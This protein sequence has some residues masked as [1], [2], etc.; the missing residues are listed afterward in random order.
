MLKVDLHIHT[1]DDPIDRI[2]HSSIELIDRAAEL[3]YGAIAITLHDRQIETDELTEY[4][5]KRGVVLIPGIERTV[6]GRHVLLLNFPAVAESVENFDDIA[7]L[8]V[9]FPNGLVVAP[10][11]F[12]PHSNCLRGLAD[13]YAQLFD[14]VELNGFFT[15]MLDFNRR[16]IKWARRRGKPV[17]ANSDAHRMYLFGRSYSLVDA[18]P[19][20]DAICRAIKAGR[21]EVRLDPI[22]T[23]E[24]VKY[25][26]ALTFFARRRLLDTAGCE[27]PGAADAR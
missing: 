7:V 14:A 11:P 9:R 1:A 8:K 17:V 18:E 26:G 12:F 19:A 27:L 2:P 5:R 13:R 22:S 10:H 15:R 21:V 16:A 6:R 3:G 20:P 4:A 23:W 24:A 25:F